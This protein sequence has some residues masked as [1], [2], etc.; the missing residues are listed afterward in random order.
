MFIKIYTKSQLV[1]LRKV[2]KLMG[3][4]K[5]PKEIIRKVERILYDKKLGKNGFIAIFLEPIKNDVIQIFDTLDCYPITLELTDNL[6]GIDIKDTKSWMTKGNEWYIDQMTVKG[7]KSYV[8]I[9]YYMRIKDL[10]K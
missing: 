6:T 1:L 9:F 10:Y 2:N 5:I 7:G 3:K 8:W 4:Y